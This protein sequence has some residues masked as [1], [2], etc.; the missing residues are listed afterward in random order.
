MTISFITSLLEKI[1]PLSLQEDYD[2]AGLI[3][4]NKNW[5]CKGALVCL[6][7]TEE[8]LEEAIQQNCNLIIA[9]HPIVFKG[10]KKFSGNSYVERAVIKAIKNDIAIYACHT[11]LDNIISG[12]NGRIA[13]QL[14]LVNRTILQPKNGFIEKLQLFSPAT[15]SEIVE[16]ALF[17]AGAGQIGNYSECSFVSEGIGSFKPGD[18]ANPFI[19]EMDIRHKGNELKI[20]VIYPKWLRHQVLSAMKSAHPY[21]EVAYEISSLL[22]VYQEVGSGILGELPNDMDAVGFLKIL[23]D[24]FHQKCIKHTS[25]NGRPIKKVAICGGAG[26][27]LTQTAIAAGADIFVTS[28]VKYHEFFDADGKIILAD[29]GHF[30]SEQYTIDLIYDILRQNFPTFAVLKTKVNS[31]PVHYFVNE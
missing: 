17:E 28:D 19:G 13:D 7:V 27:F 25:L 6:D 18:G 11:N 8:I 23:S 9:H 2:N 24:A 4:G 10:I 3:T 29:I 1:A 12:V 30:E 5:E 21:E 14:G 26:S 22:N 31:N 15:H 20:E 16:K